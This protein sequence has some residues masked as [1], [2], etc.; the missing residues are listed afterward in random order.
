MG[1]ES[2]T[3]LFVAQCLNQLRY[4]VP[5]SLQRRALSA[6]ST[7]HLYPQEIFM[8]LISIGYRGSTVVKVLC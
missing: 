4:H 7:G 3:F 5:H 2:A 8:V 6:L 1:I